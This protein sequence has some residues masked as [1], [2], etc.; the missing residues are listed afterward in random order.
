MSME[1]EGDTN[2]VIMDRAVDE[3]HM[4]SNEDLFA[5]DLI[6]LRPNKI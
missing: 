5:A 2:N 6:L 3:S 4:N 1:F